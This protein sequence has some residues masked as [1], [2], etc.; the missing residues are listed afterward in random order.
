M[1]GDC[2]NPEVNSDID[3]AVLKREREHYAEELSLYGVWG[4]GLAVEGEPD[5]STFVW[6][7]EG[8]DMLKTLLACQ[9]HELLHEMKL[10]KLATICQ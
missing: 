6:G 4:F 10:R 9:A 1:E 3:P 2:F 5:Y 7:Y 8:K